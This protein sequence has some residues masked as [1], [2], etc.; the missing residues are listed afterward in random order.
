MATITANIELNNDIASSAIA[1]AQE[2]NLYKAGGREG[3]DTMT[4]VSKI[5][6][7]TNHVDLI[8]AT[9]VSTSHNYVYI[10]NPS[11]N[12]SEYFHITLGSA[13][14]GSGTYDNGTLPTEEIGRLY[15]GDW[16]FIPWTADTDED[17]GIKPSV[18]TKMVVEF[19]VFS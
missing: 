4:S 14:I 10:A 11:T 13:E 17:I 15:G 5:L 3:M 7:S 1:V 16:M 12:S 2:M 6:T 8:T 9:S 19:I 18:A